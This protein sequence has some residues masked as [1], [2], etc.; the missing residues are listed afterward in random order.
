MH[1]GNGMTEIKN[2]VDKVLSWVD[3]A[4]MRVSPVVA[5][6]KSG[7][8]ISDKVRDNTR[9]FKKDK[10]TNLARETLNECSTLS[11]RDKPEQRL[12]RLP[13]PH[14]DTVTKAGYYYHCGRVAF[15]LG[16]SRIGWHPCRVVFMLKGCVKEKS[17]SAK[18]WLLHFIPAR[19]CPLPRR[20]LKR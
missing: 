7:R 11:G 15:M 19:C 16:G 9:I 13:L 5:P 2:T 6:G 10:P 1:V 3:Q 17:L 18:A 4:D 8:G 20:F 12:L 14:G